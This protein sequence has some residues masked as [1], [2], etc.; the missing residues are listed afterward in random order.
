MDHTT[1]EQDLRREAIRRRLAGERR[2]D[3]CRALSRAT[4]WFDKWWAVYRRDPTSDLADRSRAPRTRPQQVP[5]EL[6]AAVVTTRQILTAAQTPQTRYSTVGAR[7]IAGRLAQLGFTTRPSLASIQRILR[8]A[9]L[10]QPVGAGAVK[11]YYPWPQAWAVN[12]IQATDIITRHLRGGAVIEN[13]HTIDHFS[14]AVW[15]GQYS[16]QTAA[17]TRQFLLEN[18][19]KLGLPHLHQFDNVGAFSGGHT[20]P[21]VLGQVVRLCLFCG[22]E[23]LFTPFYDAQRNWQIETFHSLWVK[24]FWTRQRFAS[25][26]E[27]RRAVPGFRTWYMQHYFPL[28][29]DGRTPRQVHQTAR[30]RRLAPALHQAVPAGR[31]PLTTGRIHFMRKV[32][33]DGQIRLLNE[34]WPVGLKRAGE[35]VRATLNLTEQRLTI[36]HQADA[37]SPWQLLK[38]R[39]FRLKEPVHDLLPAFRHNRTRCR[40]YYPG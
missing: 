30:L 26:A 9:G 17:T 1:C 8:A 24:Q 25:L 15:L 2:R 5:A 20:H 22:I 40:D 35:Y 19:A 38:T 32:T 12:T 11:A 28:A 14:H 7:T 4:S 13:F 16:D 31:L 6:V 29:L 18:W 23:P 39:S 34:A 37:D 3:I 33:G 27:V 10:T 21:R 36:W